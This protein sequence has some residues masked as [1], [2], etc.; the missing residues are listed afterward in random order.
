MHG[1]DRGFGVE[2]VEDGF[3]QDQVGAALDQALG[4]FGVVFH[5]LIKGHVAVARVIDVRRQRASAAGRTEHAGDEARL[6][7]G[8]QGLGVGHLACKARA[9]YV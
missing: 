6:V 5:Q 7:R 2:G 8:F 1:E 9:F 3:D 4:G